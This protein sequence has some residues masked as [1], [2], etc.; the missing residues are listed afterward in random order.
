MSIRLAESQNGVLVC[1]DVDLDGSAVLD[2][3]TYEVAS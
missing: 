1:A 2:E 3:N